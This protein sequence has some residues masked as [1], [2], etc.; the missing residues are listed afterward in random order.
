MFVR[1]PSLLTIYSVVDSEQGK[2]FEMGREASCSCRETKE[3]LGHFIEKAEKKAAK[4]Y[5]FLPISLT[6]SIRF[7]YM[8]FN[9]PP[10]QH[11]FL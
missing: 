1:M 6:L 9:S 7:I 5:G 4:K 8:G 10:T 2:A 11:Q 3:D